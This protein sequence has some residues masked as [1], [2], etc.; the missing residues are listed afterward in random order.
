MKIKKKSTWLK[1]RGYLHLTNQIDVSTRRGEILGLVQN[2]QLVAKHGFFPLMHTS[3][4][5]RRFKKNSSLSNERSHSFNG[6]SNAKPRPLHYATHIDSMIFG[7]Y[8]EQL[9]KEYILELYRTEGLAN[10]VTAYRRI[11]DTTKK[12]KYK[13]TIHFAHEVFEQIKVRSASNCTVLKFDIEKFF[14]SI[15]HKLL[16]KAW[17]DLLKTPSLPKDH[18]NVFKAS[19]QFSFI[20]R[21]DLKIKT[22]NSKKKSAFDERKLADIRKK[23]IVAFYESPKSLKSAIRNGDLKIYKN[24]FR[25]KLNQMVGIPQGLPISAVL[26]N[27]YLLEFDRIIYQTVVKDLNGYYRRYSDDIIVICRDEDKDKVEKIVQ[28]AIEKRKVIIN[29]TKTEVFLFDQTKKS[30]ETRI[31]I[32]K[33]D[34]GIKKANLPLTYLGF[35]FYGNKTLIKSANLAKFYRRMIFAVKSRSKR[36]II[37]SEKT[38]QTRTLFKRRLFRLYTNINLDKIEKYHKRK[39]LV[40]NKF[41]LFIYESEKEESEFKSN[42]FSYTRRARVFHKLCQ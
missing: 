9:Q 14:T 26:A 16:K 12:G 7:Y 21:A 42:Y 36:A 15:D 19:T 5:E 4:T 32:Y 25:N 33:V 34:K 22:N 8:A 11:E 3:I 23:N 37:A 20:N 18:Y 29:P 40:Q 6:V 35:D 27:L 1:N 13:S 28:D 39:R 38:G 24:S 2:E 30:D 31:N 17:I 10:C 41:D